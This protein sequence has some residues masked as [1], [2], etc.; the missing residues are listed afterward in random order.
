MPKSKMKI[1]FSQILTTVFFNLPHRLYF[2]LE[3]VPFLRLSYLVYHML[4]IGALTDLCTFLVREV[5]PLHISAA[6]QLLA[7]SL[8]GGLW[9][10]FSMEF[11]YSIAELTCSLLHFPLPIE[12]RHKNP[13]LSTSLA[14]FWGVRWNPII[15]KL[16]QDSFYKPLRAVGVSRGLCV[17]ACFCGSAVLHAV[18]QFISTRSGKDALM[19]FSFFALQGVCL[20]VEL[21]AQSCYR[22]MFYRLF[23]RGATDNGQIHGHGKGEGLKPRISRQSSSDKLDVISGVSSPSSSSTDLTQVSIDYRPP[24]A[25]SAAAKRPSLSQ[26]SLKN[27]RRLEAE[28]GMMR[29]KLAPGQSLIEIWAV[30]CLGYLAFYIFESSLTAMH[31]Q[32]CVSQVVGLLC[33]IFHL[34]T[35]K[36]GAR[37]RLTAYDFLMGFIGW[38]WT[39]TTI[40]CLLPCFALPILHSVEELYS[41]SFIVGPLVRAYLKVY[42]RN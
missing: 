42:S 3:S 39:I 5:I 18:P 21:A 16:L 26:L 38:M 30:I 10:V 28:E 20:L 7:T 6:R 2:N 36:A 1:L 35:Y 34:E 24:A 13:L 33:C 22:Y 41:Q 14:E 4:M 29:R 31:L 40:L 15:G 11:V 25:D 37:D 12:L 23:R 8:I 32:L 27:Q 19:M 17:L 9:V